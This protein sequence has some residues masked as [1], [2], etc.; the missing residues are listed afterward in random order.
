M[1]PACHEEDRFRKRSAASGADQGGQSVDGGDAGVDIVSRIFTGYRVQWKSVD[2]Q[3]ASGV[4]SLSPSMGW[5]IPLKVRPRISGE[6]PISI[7]VR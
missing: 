2:I 3:A 1:Q 5:P 4:I 7:G 6:S